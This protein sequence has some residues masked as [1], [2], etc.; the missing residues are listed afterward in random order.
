[1]GDNWLEIADQGIDAQA[2]AR[3]IRDRMASMDK[4]SD[5]ADI[6]ETIRQEMFGMPVDTLALDKR[7]SIWQQECDIVPRSY[8]IDW[9]TPILGP[10][11]AFVRRIINAE[12]RRYLLPVLERQSYLNQKILQAFQDLT[13]ENARMRREVER[14]QGM[15]E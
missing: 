7:I 6:V 2:I 11:H 13:Q 4:A 12:I 5:P 15:K 14:L 3:Q 1:M 9:R 10:I 8:V